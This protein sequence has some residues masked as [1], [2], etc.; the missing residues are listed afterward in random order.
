VPALLVLMSPPLGGLLTP[1][2]EETTFSAAPLMAVGFGAAVGLL[3]GRFAAPPPARAAW[4]TGLRTAAV[5]WLGVSLVIEVWLGVLFLVP[6]P[7]ALWPPLAV[8]QRQY[9]GM[10][11]LSLLTT[12]PESA[13]II[14]VLGLPTALFAGALG[15]ALGGAQFSHS[16]SGATPSAST[17]RL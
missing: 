3:A 14:L 4:R 13:I 9:C 7:V 12:I 6:V 11:G 1:L 8:C 15:G 5:G 16:G 17:M 10:S 2:P